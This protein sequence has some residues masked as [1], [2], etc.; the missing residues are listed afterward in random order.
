MECK[1][2]AN[3]HGESESPVTNGRIQLNDYW[4]LYGKLRYNFTEDLQGFAQVKTC[5]MK[6]I[7]HSQ[8]RG[9]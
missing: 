4:Q 8:K 2:Y 1:P 6:I 3:W 7:V 5:Q 9:I